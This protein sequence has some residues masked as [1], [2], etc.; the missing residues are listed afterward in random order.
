VNGIPLGIQL[1]TTSIL[2]Q[3]LHSEYRSILACKGLRLLKGGT[4]QSSCLGIYHASIFI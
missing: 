3:S 1:S 4:L 2:I